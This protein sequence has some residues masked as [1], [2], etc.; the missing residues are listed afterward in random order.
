[1]GHSREEREEAKDEH[2]LKMQRRRVQQ[3]QQEAGVGM[4]RV[5]NAE[6]KALEAQP[7]AADGVKAEPKAAVEAA[8]AT[9]PRPDGPQTASPKRK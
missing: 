1:M 5:G 2:A 3:A 8:E 6:P 9:H 7:M 4:A